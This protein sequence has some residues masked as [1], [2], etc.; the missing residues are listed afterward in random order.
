[1]TVQLKKV[2]LKEGKYEQYQAI[3]QAN[4]KVEKANLKGLY[5]A[6]TLYTCVA[7]IF[8]NARNSSE[9]TRHISP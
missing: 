2:I 3:A 5:Q 8:V 7:E 9:K 4:K 1:M 6:L